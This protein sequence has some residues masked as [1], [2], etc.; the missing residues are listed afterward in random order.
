VVLYANLG[1]MNDFASVVNLLKNA[2]DYTGVFGGHPSPTSRMIRNRYRILAAIIHP[3]SNPDRTTEATEA[4]Q[5]L[6]QFKEDAD[7]A[8]NAGTFGQPVR[9]ATIRTKGAVH[10][11]LAKIGIGDVCQLY[12]TRTT[13]DTGELTGFLKVAQHAKNNDLV[14]AEAKALK[15]L[16]SVDDKFTRHIPL[17]LDTFLYKD[18]R[19]QA[20]VIVYQGDGYDGEQIKG[21]FGDDL[22]PVHGV[23]MW[24]R[25]LMGL[26]FAHDQGVIHGAVLPPHVMILPEQHGVMLMDWCY[27]TIQPPPTPAGPLDVKKEVV[28]EPY[29][30]IKAIVSEYRDWYPEEVLNKEA[31][32]PATDII[33]AVRTMIYLM[34]G[35][36]LTGDLPFV[37]PRQ[38]RAFF[39]GCLQTRQS[40]R[41]QN[42]WLLLNE[43][44]GLLKR[45]GSPY[46]PRRF[47]ELAVPAAT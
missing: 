6:T 44:D 43:F 30:R 14:K 33:M 42:V 10:E 11:V 41:P 45:I 23:W 40:M 31:P 39:K 1:K 5:I 47:V 7:F 38:M 35:D 17:L 26:G 20:N 25:L 9:L 34:G 12:R 37:I 15:K 21:I 4:F 24:R 36:P 16:H 18:G 29:P 46:Y 3:D 32:T 28:Q 13:V 2:S 8:L 19:R 22:E 27:S